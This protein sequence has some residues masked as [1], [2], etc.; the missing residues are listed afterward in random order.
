MSSEGQFQLRKLTLSGQIL[1][2]KSVK[3]LS[4]EALSENT[5]RAC[6]KRFNNKD[7]SLEN[8]KEDNQI[9]KAGGQ[10]RII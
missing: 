6:C 5:V 2:R 4:K 3:A 7:W 8:Q 10:A 9:S 1:H